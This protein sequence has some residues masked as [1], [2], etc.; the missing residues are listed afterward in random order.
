LDSDY[1]YVGGPLDGL[2]VTLTGAGAGV[3]E[4]IRS[5]SLYY[6]QRFKARYVRAGPRYI[7]DGWE[8]QSFTTEH[9]QR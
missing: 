5:T 2:V 1:Q 6:G 3:P 4:T 9:R 7:H 8:I